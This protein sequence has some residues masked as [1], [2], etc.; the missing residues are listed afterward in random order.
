VVHRSVGRV[1]VVA[2]VWPA[3]ASALVLATVW[4]FGPVS[5]LSDIVL[6]L[7][8]GS[9]T[10]YGFVL[11]RR[12]RYRDHR[13]WM[14]RSFA[15]TISILFNRLLGLPI[16]LFLSSR[17]DTMFGGDELAMQQAASAIATWLPWTLAFIA[18]EWWLDHDQRRESRA[19]GQA[20]PEL[21]GTPPAAIVREEA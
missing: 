9:V 5:A 13:R 8:W 7:L 20:D 10:T 1:Y 6:A 2:G 4:P 14:L 18:V 3:A 15:L 16:W 21:S 11:G 17:I 12:R 19:L